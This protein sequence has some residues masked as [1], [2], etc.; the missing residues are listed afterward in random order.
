MN[1]IIAL[2]AISIISLTEY[3]FSDEYL[4]IE[5]M[6]GILA[7]SKI[8]EKQ[9]AQPATELADFNTKL[10]DIDANIVKIN[11]LREKGLI[12]NDQYQKNLS[13]Q[14]EKREQIKKEVMERD[15]NG[16][17]ECMSK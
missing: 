13:A 14:L 17:K 9:R 4:T 6:D 1:T 7:K 11:K 15:G 2:I 12:S 3:G 8:C 10:N 16:F 5:E